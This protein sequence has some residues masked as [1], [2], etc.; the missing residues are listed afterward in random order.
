MSRRLCLDIRFLGIIQPMALP[1]TL[2]V[3][4]GLHGTP[5][6]RAEDLLRQL[7]G[8]ADQR[9][10]HRVSTAPWAI[11]M[12]VDLQREL[13]DAAE[14]LALTQT[15]IVVGLLKVFLPELVRAAEPPGL[16]ELPEELTREQAEAIIAKLQR[17]FQEG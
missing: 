2:P 7:K 16:P 5:L 14:K 1:T 6:E 9:R 10:V 17:K 8:L 11:R 3:R 15:A 13:G 4:G 12:D